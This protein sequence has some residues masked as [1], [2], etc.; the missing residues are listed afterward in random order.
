MVKDL[1]EFDRDGKIVISDDIVLKSVSAGIPAIVSKGAVTN[2]AVR[3]GDFRGDSRW[4]CKKRGM[5]VYTG[6]VGV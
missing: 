6:E 4:V 1:D 5:V 2:L 3:V